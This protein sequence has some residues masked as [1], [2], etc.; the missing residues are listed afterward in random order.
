MDMTAINLDF[1]GKIFDEVFFVEPDFCIST[2]KHTRFVPSLKVRNINQT[3][4]YI[5]NEKA[6]L[7]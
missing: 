6:Y 3:E 2:W 4:K 5:D 7:L 1:W